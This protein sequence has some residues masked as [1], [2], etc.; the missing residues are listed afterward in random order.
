MKNVTK[1]VYTFR[2]LLEME[3]SGKV[4]A[5]AVEKARNWLSDIDSDW[6]DGIIEKWHELLDCIGFY[7]III[8]F[9]GFWSQGDGASFTCKIDFQIFAEFL[10]TE[11][12]ENNEH[13]GT[14]AYLLHTIGWNGINKNTQFAWLS[15]FEDYFQASIQRDSYRYSH[16]NTCSFELDYSSKADIDL[17]YRDFVDLAE[18]LR[19]DICRAIYLDLEQG[20][21]YQTSD[22]CLIE[23]SWVNDYYF[24]ENGDFES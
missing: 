14:P 3:E 1:T 11:R 2:E 15:H 19:K 17:V 8:E 20:Y 24:D 7:D 12:Q 18:E 5:N 9:S 10:A 23:Q 21:E 16:E 13:Y 4:S 6:S 22:E